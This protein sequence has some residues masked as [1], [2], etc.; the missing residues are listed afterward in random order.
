MTY[1]QLAVALLYRILNSNCDHNDAIN[2]INPGVYSL[3]YDNDVY[4]T[5]QQV[6]R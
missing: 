4:P 5:C 6:Y 2:I 3:G 1:V